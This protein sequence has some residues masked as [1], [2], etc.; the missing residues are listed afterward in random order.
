MDKTTPTTE[1]DKP[2]GHAPAP[3]TPAEPAE[4]ITATAAGPAP[5]LRVFPLHGILDDPA[6][7]GEPICT[8]PKGTECDRVGKHPML[9]WRNYDGNTKGPSGGYGIQTGHFNGI[10]VVDLD[11]GVNKD[12]TPKSGFAALDQLAA[13]RPVPDTLRVMTPSGGVHLYFNLPPDA[14]VPCSRS[15]LAPGV[16]VRG[17]GGFVVGPGSPHKSGGIYQEVPGP[18]CDAPEWLLALVI[19]TIEPT[20]ELTTE[21]RTIEPTSPEGIHAIAWA[22]T[23]LANAEP[24][25]EGQGGSD[26]LFHACC[27]LMYSAL[28]LDVLR[29]LV[30]DVYNP[31]CEPPWSTQEIEHK[32]EDAD[33]ISEEPR[34][35]CPPG[36]SD[37][38][39]GRTTDT[40]AKEP[41]PLHEYTFKV[42]MRG[43]GDSRK[44]SVGEVA[45]DLFDQVGW[46][47]VLRFDSFRDRVVAVNPPMKLDAEGPLGLS[48]NDVQLVRVWLEF[49]GKK[50]NAQDVGAAIEAVA[51]RHS[52]NPI[53]DMLRSL[54]WDEA[55]RLDRVLPE[56]FQSP[57]S[58]YERAIGPRWFIAL[59]AR[60]MDPG[61]QSDSTLILEGKQGHGKTTAFRSLMRDPT[62]Y[63]ESSCGVD[64]KDFF[65]N[66]RGVWLMGFDELD[67]LTRASLTK[68]KTV[69][70]ATRDRYRK[71]YGRH[72]TDY[73]RACGFCGSTNA[74]QYF[75][76][77][78]GARRFWPVRV[79]R[80]INVQRIVDDRDQLWAEAFARWRSGE[81]WHVNTPELLALCEAEQEERQEID[82]WEEVVVRWFHDPTKFSHT[83]ITA[84]P[85]SVFR[86]MQPFDG[87]QGVTTADVIEHAVGKLKGQWTTGDAMRV[88][89]ILQRLKMKRKQIWLGKSDGRAHRVWRYQF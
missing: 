54:E 23:Y 79:L 17:H 68:V 8:C 62:W 59:V 57:D 60:A 83:P 38:M 56:Y 31:R 14:Y 21:H 24:A 27:H 44:A 20:K 11:V 80:E 19:K 74:E 10:F 70:T 34:G 40:G 51:R 37:R 64:S 13:G 82:G 45:A 49:N 78:T 32:L 42:G 12:G 43:S 50:C 48:N 84:E 7:P 26:R 1:F 4:R 16:D 15:E 9:P 28:P 87:S 2:N 47:G 41:D 75:N 65:E 36:F 52:F 29:Q 69:L 71:S 39:L 81:E 53:Q 77:P 58:E 73:P 46:A 35:L 85:S 30:E 55:P 61:C 89:R 5:A 86:G 66:L 67:S 18:L 25:I 22:Q 63:A 88:G 72:S 33:G 6:H 76:D 3:S